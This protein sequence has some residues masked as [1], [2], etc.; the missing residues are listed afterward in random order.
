MF[1][2]VRAYLSIIALGLAAAS[3]AAPRAAAIPP[4]PGAMARKAPRTD[5]CEPQGSTLAGVCKTTSFTLAN[6]AWKVSPSEGFV[7]YATDELYIF[8]DVSFKSGTL[9]ALYAPK[10]TITGQVFGA[11]ADGPRT[12]NQPPK[13][14]D[15]IDSCDFHDTDQEIEIP[16]GD[17]LAIVADKPSG[18]DLEFGG[19]ALWPAA[20]G[21]Q[22]TKLRQGQ[23]GGNIL[24]GTP[25]A[26]DAARRV[27]SQANLSVNVKAFPPST[28]G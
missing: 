23:D 21:G 19:I 16:S 28:F 10:I 13:V 14:T 22:E 20:A 26:R 24:I 25:A 15:V 8:G 5:P 3:C 7:V 9:L 12:A 27:A 11:N 1:R 18:C 4:A 17:D 2:R 6:G